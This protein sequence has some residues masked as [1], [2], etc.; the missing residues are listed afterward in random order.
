L[1]FCFVYDA[2]KIKGNS[3][4]EEANYPLKKIVLAAFIS[5]RFEGLPVEKHDINDK[6]FRC[7]KLGY[8]ICILVPLSYNMTKRIIILPNQILYVLDQHCIN[9]KLHD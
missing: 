1:V 3:D 9:M 7:F 5:T 6:Y 8:E 4:K 2:N